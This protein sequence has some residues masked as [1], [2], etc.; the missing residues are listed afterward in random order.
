MIDRSIAV[1][2]VSQEPYDLP[3]KKQFLSELKLLF[4]Q[5]IKLYSDSKTAVSISHNPIQHDR[6]KHIKIDRHFIKEK[7]DGVLCIPFTCTC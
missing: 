2:A 4:N 7:V 3:R 1:Q 6:A 5:P